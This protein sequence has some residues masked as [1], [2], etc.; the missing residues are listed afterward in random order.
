MAAQINFELD[1]QKTRSPHMH[2]NPN[3][4]DNPLLE[5]QVIYDNNSY[6]CMYVSIY[7]C[8]HV[9]TVLT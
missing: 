8:M 9:H 3:E 7:I 6:P 4:T 5:A 1:Y 2:Q